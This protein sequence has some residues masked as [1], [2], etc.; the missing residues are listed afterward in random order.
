[1]QTDHSLAETQSIEQARPCLCMSA[2]IAVPRFH[3]TTLLV[4][5]E[6]C[7]PDW[8]Q[9]SPCSAGIAI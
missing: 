5:D 2:W 4:L 7:R 8:L 6:Y 1:M 3:N 9:L